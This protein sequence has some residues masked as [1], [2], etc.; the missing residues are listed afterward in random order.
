MRPAGWVGCCRGAVAAATA[1]AALL[2]LQPGLGPPSTTTWPPLPRRAAGL[3]DSLAKLR[4]VVALCAGLGVHTAPARVG[5]GLWVA[6][7]WSRHHAS[8]DSEPDVPGVPPAS[9][10]T[11]ADYSACAWPPHLPSGGAAGSAA[12]AEWFDSLN[13]G[14]AWEALLAERPRC[15]VV[16]VSHFLPRQVPR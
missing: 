16:S 6:P 10:W 12:L 13:D 4:R 9:H 15:D 5:A 11:V 14:P 2:Q 7:L 8:F 3:H 1:A